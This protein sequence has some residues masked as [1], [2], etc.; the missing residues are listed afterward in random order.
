MIGFW[1][2]KSNGPTDGTVAVTKVEIRIRV[3]G[4]DRFV[5]YALKVDAPDSDE[6]KRRVLRVIGAGVEMGCALL[7]AEFEKD[8]FIG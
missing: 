3:D 8:E 1:R 5:R 2:P 6:G 7:D 4:E